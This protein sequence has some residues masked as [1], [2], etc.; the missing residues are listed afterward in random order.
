[1]SVIARPRPVVV[2]IALLGTPWLLSDA[3]A[4]PP[5]TAKRR[6]RLVEPP[7]GAVALGSAPPQTVDL[8]L[9]FAGIW[10]VIQ[11]EDSGDTHVGYA[12]F[13]L[14]FVPAERLTSKT[15]ERRKRLEDF[16]CFGQ[17]VLAPA[18]GRVL[19]ARDGAV[20]H[21][22]Y[23]EGKHEPGNFVILEHAP[24]EYTEF[25]HLKSG[26]VAVKVGDTVRR[27]QTIARCGNSG[28]SNTPHV[29]VGFLGS[30][31]PIATR[32]MK[33][34]HYELLRPDGKWHPGD[35]VPRE[36]EILRALP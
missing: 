35:G 7:A 1:M 23:Y 33:F 5:A 12:A 11:G 13:A 31:D 21:A 22:P 9:P 26:S 18:D 14:D 32:P 8:R 27:G 10:G 15:A 30:V 24:A 28:N 4:A 3:A 29:H 17:P 20:D 2:A 25:R 36:Q 6:A 19:W 16:P 34:S